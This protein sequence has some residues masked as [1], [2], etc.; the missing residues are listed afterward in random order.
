MPLPTI[1]IPPG[2]L[3]DGASGRSIEPRCKSRTMIGRPDKKAET[4]DR[5]S[6]FLIGFESWLSRPAEPAAASS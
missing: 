5:R 6:V 4:G 2:R 1:F 3:G